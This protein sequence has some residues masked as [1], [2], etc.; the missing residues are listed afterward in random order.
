[1]LNK[2]E[3]D[4]VE[5]AIIATLEEHRLQPFAVLRETG[6]VAA[7][8]QLLCAQTVFQVLAEAQLIDSRSANRSIDRPLTASV[9]V[10]RVQMEVTANARLQNEPQ[11]WKKTVDIGIFG[12]RPQL[13]LAPNGPGDVL[14]QVAPGDLAAAIEVKA[15]PSSDRRQRGLYAE[16][17][18]TLLWMKC[19]FGID[20]HFVLFDKTHPLYGPWTAPT[21]DRVAMKWDSDVAQDIEF[22]RKGKPDFVCR[23]LR[24]CGLS[25]GEGARDDAVFGVQMWAL[26]PQT[27]RPQH[28]HVCLVDASAAL[29]DYLGFPA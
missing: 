2:T 24:E 17:L 25:I 15:S 14:E 13:R 7:L 27:A 9:Q 8:R 29:M 23:S 5:A 26:H 22:R 18:L 1:M 19:H 12:L 28:E 10:S 11:L 16:D 20:G 4:A 21:P 6:A 3:S